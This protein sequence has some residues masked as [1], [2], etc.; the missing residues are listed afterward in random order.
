MRVD[1]YEVV[2]WFTTPKELRKIAD[3]MESRWKT[4]KLGEDTTIQSVWT[5]ETQLHIM[6]DQDHINAK[7]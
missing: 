2:R 4:I 1:R 5:N 7:P 6:I 3:E